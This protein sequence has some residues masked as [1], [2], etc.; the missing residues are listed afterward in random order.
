MQ[1]AIGDD[2]PEIEL[3]DDYTLRTCLPGDAPHWARIISESFE[4]STFDAARFDS[5]ME[6]DPA[7]QA[8]RIFF[9]CA[10]GGTPCATASA[11]RK[12]YFGPDTG[13]VH[14]V[15]VLP[16]HASRKLG[17]AV[18]LAVLHHFHREGL[19]KAVLETDDF[20]LGAIK[21][22][23]RLGFWPLMHHES[24]AV[25]WDA[26]FAK[27]EGTGKMI[28]A[29]SGRASRGKMIRIPQTSQ[30]KKRAATSK[31]RSRVR[32]ASNRPRRKAVFVSPRL[33]G[34]PHHPAKRESR[35]LSRVGR[36]L[37]AHYNYKRNQP[38]LSASPPPPINVNQR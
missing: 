29:A 6:G 1:R 27:L 18:S 19:T 33:H 4:N 13:Y 12:E 34:Q 20:R 22:Y 2:L 15:G 3:P 21:T 28:R 25:R 31:A 5:E 9:M 7:Y 26:V 37:A 17:L 8:E 24:H 30:I 16:A 32:L 10:P 11:W 14:Y 36:L 35:T 23:C 38:Y